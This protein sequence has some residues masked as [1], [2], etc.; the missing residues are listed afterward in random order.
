MRVRLTIFVV[1]ALGLVPAP[2]IAAPQDIAATH[3]YIQANH[4][5]AQASVSRIGAAQAKIERFNAKLASECPRVGIG[6][7][8]DEASQPVSYEVTVALWSIADGTD[9]GPIRAFLGA[10]GRLH[11]GNHSIDRIAE[12][13]ARSLHELATLPLPDLCQDVRSWKASGF[14]IIPAASLSLVHRVEA[15]E[16]NPIPPRL[17]APYERGADAS[18][19]TSTTHLEKRLEENEFLDGQNDWIQ[20]LQTL[21]LNE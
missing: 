5:L 12:T 19:L 10:A 9:A 6:S 18:I 21:G 1:L 3:A 15:I 17:L 20:V 8:Q 14:Q 13:Y 7:P 4:A 11:W 2:A 16:L